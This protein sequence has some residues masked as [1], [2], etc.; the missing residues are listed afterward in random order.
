M[1]VDRPA[2]VSKLF[3]MEQSLPRLHRPINQSLLLKA[4]ADPN[5]AVLGFGLTLMCVCVCAPVRSFE[6]SADAV[7][8]EHLQGWDA[9]SGDTHSQDRALSFEAYSKKAV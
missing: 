1:F 3:K 8:A 2:P 5:R 7:G 9:Y 4:Q 6:G